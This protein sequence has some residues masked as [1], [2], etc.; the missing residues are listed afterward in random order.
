MHG[1]PYAVAPDVQKRVPWL[2]WLSPAFAAR[3]KLDAAC[4]AGRADAPLSHDHLFHSLLGL[5]AV[6]TQAYKPG[7]DAYAA[8]RK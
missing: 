4:L 3:Q 1:L 7:L 8:C 2:T 6:Q 5:A